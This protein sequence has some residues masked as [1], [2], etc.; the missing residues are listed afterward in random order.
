[1][2]LTRFLVSTRRR[3]FGQALCALALCSSLVSQPLRAATFGGVVS[4]DQRPGLL[5]RMGFT[6]QMTTLP[7]NVDTSKFHFDSAGRRIPD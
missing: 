3:K 5:D 1:M 4:S 2:Q 7:S 6:P